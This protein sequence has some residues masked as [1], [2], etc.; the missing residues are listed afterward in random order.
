LKPTNLKHDA[1]AAKSF[2]DKLKPVIGNLVEVHN[3]IL[4]GVR[5]APDTPWLEFTIESWTGQHSPRAYG[6][7]DYKVV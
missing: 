6:F 4:Q 1:A 3:G 7:V 2:S 5:I